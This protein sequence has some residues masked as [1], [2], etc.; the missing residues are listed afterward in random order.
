MQLTH[1][2]GVASLVLLFCIDV[3]IK[4][5]HAYFDEKRMVNL[6]QNYAGNNVECF[7]H[8]SNLVFERPMTLIG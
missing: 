1:D 3:D 8:K 6:E 4:F 2:L 5:K 7:S